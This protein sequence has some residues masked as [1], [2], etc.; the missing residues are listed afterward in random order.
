MVVSKLGM[1]LGSGQKGQ[2]YIWMGHRSPGSKTWDL[3][4]R[5]KHLW[6]QFVADLSSSGADPL[7]AIGWQNSGPWR[8]ILWGELFRYES[9]VDVI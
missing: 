8:F 9:S 1:F 7:C 4:K 5:S 2:G 6:E 3:A